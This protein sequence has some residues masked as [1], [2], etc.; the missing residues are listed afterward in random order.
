MEIYTGNYV[1]Y[2][3]VGLLNVIFIIKTLSYSIT[4]YILVKCESEP[5]FENSICYLF[6]Y[7][8][9]TSDMHISTKQQIQILILYT[10]KLGLF[11]KKYLIFHHLL[12]QNFSL[13]PYIRNN[14]IFL[15]YFPNSNNFPPR[16]LRQNS[17]RFVPY[18]CI[19]YIVCNC[20]N[21]MQIISCLAMQKSY[22]HSY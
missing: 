14:S 1:K 16:F 18:V 21:Y 5:N 17:I 20:N 3:G 15:F 12:Q 8:I 7:K 13:T 2:N 22:E 19:M 11:I 4:A 6:T 9:Q 10:S